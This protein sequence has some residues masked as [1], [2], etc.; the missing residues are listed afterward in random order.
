MKT[1]RTELLKEV[2]G[3]CDIVGFK[4][5]HNPKPVYAFRDVRGNKPKI[6]YVGPDK[7]L[8]YAFALARIKYEYEQFKQLS[9]E[10][11]QKED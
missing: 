9:S 11:E 5:P 1:M 3:R 7:E 2:K 8:I 6:L 10:Q 4:T